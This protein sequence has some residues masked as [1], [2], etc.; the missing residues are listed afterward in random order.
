MEE[1]E[2]IL[3]EK[4]KL[5]DNTPQALL[6]TVIYMNGVYCALRSG[7]E[8]KNLHFFRPRRS[9]LLTEMEKD[10]TLNS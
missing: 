6:N 2:E 3:W 10:H 1:E 5:G 9:T 8:Y 7:K 4:G